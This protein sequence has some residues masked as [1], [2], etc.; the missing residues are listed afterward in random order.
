MIETKKTRTD[1]PGSRRYAGIT[2]YDSANR[3]TVGRAIR[4]NGTIEACDYL[5]VEG[6]VD[7]TL[8]KA[9]RLD[10]MHCGT[11]IGTVVTEQAVIAG[12]FDGDLTVSGRLTVRSTAH[13]SGTVRYGALDVEPGATL[14]AALVRNA[15]SAAPAVDDVNR[16]NKPAPVIAGSKNAIPAARPRVA[17]AFAVFEGGLDLGPGGKPQGEETGSAPVKFRARG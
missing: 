12:R 7:A 16:E 4:L 3:L 8:P 14:D 13:I 15:P 9:G 11:F 17:P 6:Y 1:I 5:V 2:P 10:V